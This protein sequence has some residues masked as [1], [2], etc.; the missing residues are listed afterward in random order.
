MQQPAYASPSYSWL[1]RKWKWKKEQRQEKESKGI[2]EKKIAEGR[3]RKG[4]KEQVRKKEGQLKKERPTAPLKWHSP[5]TTNITGYLH[6]TFLCAFAQP[7]RGVVEVLLDCFHRPLVGFYPDDD[8]P[9]FRTRVPQR[10]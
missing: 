10:V 1:S 9:Q 2:G 3:K 6:R 8:R 7:E 5:I 4:E